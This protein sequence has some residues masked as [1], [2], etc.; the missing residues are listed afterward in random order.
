MPPST[1][2]GAGDHTPA[3]RPPGLFLSP[4]RWRV[5]VALHDSGS[6]CT[7]AQIAALLGLHANTARTHLDALVDAGLARR[8]RVPP[9]GRGRPASSYRSVPLEPG[10]G[11]TGASLDGLAGRGTSSWPV[12]LRSNRTQ[13]A[14]E[15][16]SRP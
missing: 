16:T 6:A 3:Y 7:V 5:L 14:T 9:H 2:P 4:Q 8:Q 12:G 11:P 15:G 10:A 1:E 13:S